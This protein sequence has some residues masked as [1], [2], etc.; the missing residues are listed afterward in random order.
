M[1]NGKLIFYEDRQLKLLKDIC[2]CDSA[3]GFI[4]LEETRFSTLIN[5]LTVKLVLVFIDKVDFDVSVSKIGIIITKN[6]FKNTK[7]RQIV[8]VMSP[9]VY[10]PVIHTPSYPLLSLLPS[11]I[12]PSK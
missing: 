6:G 11:N 4:L 8:S 9:Y 5:P 12:I 3:S 10:R 2:R 7:Q 1:A